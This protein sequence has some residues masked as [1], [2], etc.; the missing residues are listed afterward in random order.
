MSGGAVSEEFKYLEAL[1]GELGAREL[2]WN[3]LD[4]VGWKEFRRMAPAVVGLELGRIE[5]LIASD[6]IGS[7]TYNSLVGVR[8]SLKKFSDGL[9][10]AG[11]ESLPD[12]AAHL[13]HALLAVSMLAGT[14]SDDSAETLRY[15]SLRLNF[16]HNRINLV[17]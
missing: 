12:R 16:I 5:R 3:E 13:R 14:V 6:E 7:D 11:R 2:E 8:F 4:F 15:V 1:A 10:L 9:D 17:Y